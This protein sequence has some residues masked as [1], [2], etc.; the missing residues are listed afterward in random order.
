MAAPHPCQ[1]ALA[2]TAIS[3]HSGDVRRSSDLDSA[4]YQRHPNK[5]D[6]EEARGSSPR[7]PTTKQEDGGRPGGPTNSAQDRIAHVGAAQLLS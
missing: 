5:P 6:K 2:L 3:G 1:N 4:R 7:S